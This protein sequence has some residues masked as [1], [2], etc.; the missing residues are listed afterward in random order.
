M[1][2]LGWKILPTVALWV[3]VLFLAGTRF[4]HLSATEL[5]DWDEA[6]YAWRARVCL[7]EGVWIDQSHHCI[8]LY[9]L[10]VGGM[11]SGAFPPLYIWATAGMFQVFGYVEW[12]ARFWAAAA[13]A[14]CVILIF[15]I[16]RLLAGPPCGLLAAWLLAASR[17]FTDY[18]RMGQFDIPFIFFVLLTIWL[19][20]LAQASGR[21]VYRVLAG[22]ALGLG[23]MTKI[24]MALMAPMVLGMF[25][26]YRIAR[27]EWTWRDLAREQV[28]L[29]ALAGL[30][31]APWYLAMT[32]RMGGVFWWWTLR[33]HLLGKAGEGQ[34][35]NTGNWTFYVLELAQRT[36]A[37]F[38]GLVLAGLALGVWAVVAGG[39]RARV[40]TDDGEAEP[41]PIAPPPPPPPPFARSEANAYA[42]PL[43]WFLFFFIAFTLAGTKRSTYMLPLY[44]PLCLLAALPPALS[45]RRRHATPFPLLGG[46]VVV[47]SAGL[48]A[49]RDSSYHRAIRD[50]VAE[51]AP[52]VGAGD[53][54]ALG[55][56]VLGWSMLFGAPWAAYLLYFAGRRF[57]GRG[58]V[59]Q[60]VLIVLMAG[61]VIGEGTAKGLRYAFAIPRDREE[62]G[63]HRL[64]RDISA[65]D[66][67]CILAVGDEFETN[68]A[69]FYLAG[70]PMGWASDTAFVRLPS[71]E[72]AGTAA[73]KLWLRRREE[74]GEERVI[75]VAR[76]SGNE[77]HDEELLQA[78]TADGFWTLRQQVRRIAL[79]LPA[80]DDAL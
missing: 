51:G 9:H 59:F 67:D 65:R 25:G 75:L 34:D 24:A 18:S 71:V 57:L 42:L 31:I 22:V 10:P 23:L 36:P 33:Y 58:P 30:V 21:P 62:A 14:G 79:L 61:L 53:L 78:L 4:F 20:L 47:M 11:Y 43:L 52:P 54:I 28:V 40:R 69:I 16:G 46:L 76:L 2:R 15:L 49:I 3:F 29:L 72:N 38:W 60:T 1:K 8:G 12:A 63:W 35:T 68:R 39:W 5:R 41:A 80:D 27:G 70:A 48:M 6:M 45:I 64:S 44:P 55:S 19:A 13:G 37:Y 17:Y 26:L 74:K 50:L 56:S 7:Q 66:P 77:T 32:A 73:H